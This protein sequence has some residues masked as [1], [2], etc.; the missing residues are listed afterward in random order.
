MMTSADMQGPG[1]G[2]GPQAGGFSPTPADAMAARIRQQSSQQ[3][4]QYALYSDPRTR[5]MAGML[6]KGLAGDD[7]SAANLLKNTGTGQGIKD[8]SAAMMQ[9]GIIPGGNPAQMAFHTQQ[10]MATKVSV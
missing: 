7:A 3:L 1:S 6:A 5:A 4:M 8:M 2:I 10:M 9:S